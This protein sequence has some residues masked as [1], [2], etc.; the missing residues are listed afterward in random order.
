MRQQRRMNSG[1]YREYF[2]AQWDGAFIDRLLEGVP[3]IVRGR[4]LVNTSFDS[5]KLC[6][7]EEEK[8]QG[9]RSVGAFTY[10]PQ[11]TNV[12]SIPHYC[13]EEWLVFDSP[14]ELSK[15]EPVINYYGFELTGAPDDFLP[16]K[17]WSQIELVRPGSYLG[18]GD[19]WLILDRKSTRLDSSHG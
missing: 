6:P 17:L 12:G 15:W 10:S 19:R 14:T 5:G 11:V 2:W 4:F 18:L 3:D 8:E 16:S 9:W 13:F 7:S 1:H